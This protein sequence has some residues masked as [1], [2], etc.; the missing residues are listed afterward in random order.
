MM[1]SYIFGLSYDIYNNDL[2]GASLKQNGFELSLSKSFG[3][4]RNEFLRT[5]F[6]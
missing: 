3:K 2:S 6:D 5:I 1:D 4:K